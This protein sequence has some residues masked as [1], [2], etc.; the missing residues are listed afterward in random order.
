M[1]E[2]SVVLS[3][4]IRAGTFELAIDEGPRVPVT[5]KL[6]GPVTIRNPRRRMALAAFLQ[7]S[8]ADALTFSTLVLNVANLSSWL[9]HEL[10]DPL[11]DPHVGGS[12]FGGT[13]AGSVR[14]RGGTAH[15]EGVR[16]TTHH[17]Q[18]HL[19][20]HGRRCLVDIDYQGSSAEAVG[21]GSGDVV[22]VPERRLD[23]NCVHDSSLV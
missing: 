8:P 1:P 13:L 14:A 4:H 17:D 12:S 21:D 10:I 5:K 18:V 20:G 15:L 9:P 19:G 23:H 11:S 6:I 2:V 22:G 7:P 3:A 16:R